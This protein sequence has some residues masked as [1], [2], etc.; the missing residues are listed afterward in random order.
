MI[1]AFS[2][3]ATHHLYVLAS[4]FIAVG[5]V[6]QNWL[7]RKNQGKLPDTTFF[8][9]LSLLESCWAVVS[10]LAL[11]FLDFD[12]LT[13]CV[14]V[15]YLVYT[16]FGFFHASNTIDFKDNSNTMPT[17]LDDIVIGHRHINFCQSFGLVFLGLCGI[18]MYVSWAGA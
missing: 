9:L 10:G 4:T 3:P 1:L 12:N 14:P 6:I 16:V 7:L 17:S 5:I 2:L 8:Y 18:V 15:S 13:I 11:Y